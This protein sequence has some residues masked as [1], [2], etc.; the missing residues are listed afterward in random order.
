ML[1]AAHWLPDPG[2]S[3]ESVGRQLEFANGSTFRRALRNTLMATPT[4]IAD[5]GGLG[6]A[7]AALCRTSG[8][9]AIVPR[10]RWV[11]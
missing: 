6:M 8:F 2:R 5:G 11:A 10:S 7:I 4:E 1:H 3:G 9:P